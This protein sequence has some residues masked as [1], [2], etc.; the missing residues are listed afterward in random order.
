MRH[1]GGFSMTLTFTF[2]LN[3]Q[4]FELG[5]DRGRRRLVHADLL[6][7]I[8]Q[9]EQQY[10][11]GRSQDWAG[12]SQDV[13][14]DLMALGRKLFAWLDGDEGWLRAALATGVPLAIA[15]GVTAISSK[16]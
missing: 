6:A 8:E 10:Y 5:C 16:I 12:R 1:S 3:Q 15:L 13:A 9:C 14:A 11:S 4:H 7:L 2:D